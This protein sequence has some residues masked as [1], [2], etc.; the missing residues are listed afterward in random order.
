[1]EGKVTINLNMVDPLESTLL[2]LG[3]SFDGSWGSKVLEMSK[4]VEG[5]SCVYR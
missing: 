4:M 5:E 1:M 3:F 2:T